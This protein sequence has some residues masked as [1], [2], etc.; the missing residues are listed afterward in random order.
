VA[1]AF[2]AR[3]LAA[4]LSGLAV[5]S[6]LWYGSHVQE[7]YV[8][9]LSQNGFLAVSG[10]DPNLGDRTPAGVATS[11]TG[12]TA[13]ICLDA[14]GECSYNAIRSLSGLHKVAKF[15]LVSPE[16]DGKYVKILA[17]PASA[18]I[19]KLDSAKVNQLNA[20]FVPRLYVYS[21]A[22]KLVFVQKSP[23]PWVQTVEEYNESIDR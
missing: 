17:A 18:E 2:Q 11:A 13:V 7:D 5:I 20:Y 4:S 1:L 3:V 9:P 19:I 21:T 14:C 16:P 12:L 15:I 8:P 6:V 10:R 23:H 22:G